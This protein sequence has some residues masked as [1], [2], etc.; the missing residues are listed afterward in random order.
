[1]TQSPPAG[2]VLAGDVLEESGDEQGTISAHRNAAG[3]AAMERLAQSHVAVFGLGAWG[4]GAPKRWPAGVGPSPW[5]T[6]TRWG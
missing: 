1:M 6:M 4:A 5:W 3:A 2:I